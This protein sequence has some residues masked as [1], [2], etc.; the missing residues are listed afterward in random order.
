MERAEEMWELE[1]P[2][3]GGPIEA[4]QLSVWSPCRRNPR[5]PAGREGWTRRGIVSPERQ[6][7]VAIYSPFGFG[8]CI[9]DLKQIKGKTKTKHAR[10]MKQHYHG[11]ETSIIKCTEHGITNRT[12]L[13]H[14]ILPGPQKATGYSSN[15]LISAT[16]C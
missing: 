6:G 4:H 3:A 11:T 15:L 8:L 13:P 14:A 10:S 9:H 1:I 5:Q 12:Q 2:E 16:R 7:F